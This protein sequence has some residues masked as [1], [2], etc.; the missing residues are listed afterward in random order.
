MSEKPIDWPSVKFLNELLV[1]PNLSRCS[2]EMVSQAE[3]IS[4]KS[5]LFTNEDTR[6]RFDSMFMVIELA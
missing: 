5:L 2:W 3:N 1:M 4:V 6:F